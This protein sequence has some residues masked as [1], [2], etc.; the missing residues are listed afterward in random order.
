MHLETPTTLL[1]P[2]DLLGMPDGENYEL[3]DGVPREKQMGAQSG[4]INARVIAALVQYIR[5]HRLGH[6]YDSQ[7]GFRC[8]PNNRVRKPDS[9]FVAAGRL[10]NDRSPEGDITIPPD[11]AAEV[12]SPHDTYEEVMAKVADYKKVRVRL[13]WVISPVTRTVLVRRLDGTCV[14]LAENDTLSGDD[15]LPGFTCPVSELFQ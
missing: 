14:E 5:Q 2:D 10:P 11:L 6:I 15:V 3:I 13:I 8:F 4:E 7:T 12:V 1:S 9:A